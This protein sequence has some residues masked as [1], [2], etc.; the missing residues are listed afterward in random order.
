MSNISPH[1]VDP[2]AT[3]H[4]LHP[5]SPRHNG[6]EPAEYGAVSEDVHDYLTTFTVG[7]ILG[8]SIIFIAIL[9]GLILLARF[10]YKEYKRKLSETDSFMLSSH[11]KKIVIPGREKKEP[12]FFMKIYK[13][14]EKSRD[15]G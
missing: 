11:E 15:E 4:T 2:K 6:G 13:K 10:T 5:S 1:T 8:I 3:D 14:I 12:S 9:A 7:E